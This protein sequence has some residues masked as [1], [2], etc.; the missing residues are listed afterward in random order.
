MY[1]RDVRHDAQRAVE[2][3]DTDRVLKILLASAGIP[4]A[5]PFRIIDGVMYVD[6]GVSGN[7]LYGGRVLEDNSFAAVWQ[8]TYPNLPIPK[9]RYWVIFNNQIRPAPQVTEPRW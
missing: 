4:A 2:T 5:F 1:V 9:L 6:G 7:I 8:K 3:G